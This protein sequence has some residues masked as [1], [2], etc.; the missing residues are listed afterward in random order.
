MPT[1]RIRDCLEIE[2]F[3][4][5]VGNMR[6]LATIASFKQSD[7]IFEARLGE[8]LLAK[9]ADKDRKLAV[10]LAAMSIKRWKIYMTQLNQRIKH[11]INY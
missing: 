4:I 2:K 7:D 9:A 5:T 1:A 8:F 11:L 10:F 6:T 3:H